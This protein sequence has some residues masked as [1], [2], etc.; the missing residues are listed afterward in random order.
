M[1]KSIKRLRFGFFDN[2]S[3][4]NTIAW[5]IYGD[6]FKR[7]EDHGLCVAMTYSGLAI[8]HE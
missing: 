8:V 3:A 5:F 4:V 7:Y 2:V 6:K 1:S